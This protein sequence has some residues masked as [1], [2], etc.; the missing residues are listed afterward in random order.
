[1]YFDFVYGIH[2]GPR[3]KPTANRREFRKPM[4]CSQNRIC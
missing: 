4:A 3:E 1:M 2:V